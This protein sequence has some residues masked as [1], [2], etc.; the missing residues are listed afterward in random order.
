[1]SRDLLQALLEARTV[2]E[3]DTPPSLVG[4]FGDRMYA[5]APSSL[6]DLEARRVSDAEIGRVGLPAG[7]AIW[8][9]AVTSTRARGEY[10]ARRYLVSV[11]VMHGD[12]REPIGMELV[13]AMTRTVLMELADAVEIAVDKCD[14]QV[15]EW[16]QEDLDAFQETL[17]K[18]TL[19][20]GSV[21]ASKRFDLQ[22]L[23]GY[24]ACMGVQLAT[25]ETS[26]SSTG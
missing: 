19:G 9:Q 18:N 7:D 17:K 22:T 12:G 14:P 4:V 15:E 20:M 13:D 6:E 3:F 23:R 16:S 5:R 2:A 10:E 8:L 26:S 1:M 25:S 21:E 11:C 24:V